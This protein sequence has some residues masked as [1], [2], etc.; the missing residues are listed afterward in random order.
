MHLITGLVVFKCKPAYST[1]IFTLISFLISFCWILFSPEIAQEVEDLNDEKFETDEE[2]ENENEAFDEL[3]DKEN[4]RDAAELEE[5]NDE[6]EET[7][8]SWSVN[9]VNKKTEFCLRFGDDIQVIMSMAKIWNFS[10]HREE[11]RERTV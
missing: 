1:L 8:K 9:L 5:M 3:R 10:T 4:E 7:G 11:T 2:L 6:D